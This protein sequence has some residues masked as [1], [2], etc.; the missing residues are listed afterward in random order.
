ML[1]VTI[2]QTVTVDKSIIVIVRKLQIEAINI[3]KSKRNK[4]MENT[5]KVEDPLKESEGQLK[6]N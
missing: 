4:N 3:M 2:K 5:V 6:Q 1:R